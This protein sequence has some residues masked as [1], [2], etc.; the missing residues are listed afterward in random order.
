MDAGVTM[1]VVIVSSVVTP[2]NKNTAEFTPRLNQYHSSAVRQTGGG[3]CTRV[4]FHMHGQHASSGTSNQAGLISHSLLVPDHS[5]VL[6]EFVVLSKSF[7]ERTL[8]IH[9]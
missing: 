4:L 8:L 5:V 7:E 3:A 9:C 2:T 1:F 6:R